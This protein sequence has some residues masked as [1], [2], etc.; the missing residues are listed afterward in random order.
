[1]IIQYEEDEN[2]KKKLL[3]INIPLIEIDTEKCKYQ[4]SFT[5]NNITIYF[6]YTP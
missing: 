4:Y 2:I 5:F 3:T 6:P 1:M